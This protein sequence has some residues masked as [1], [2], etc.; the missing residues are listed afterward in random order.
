MNAVES[1]HA[2]Y[3]S[4]T[5]LAV[6][7]R[8]QERAFS[9]FLSVGYTEDDLRCVLCYLKRENKR[10]KGAAYSLRLSKLLDFEYRHF[11][12]LLSEARAKERNRVVR[13]PAQRV[14]AQ[15]RGYTETKTGP[16]V[17]TAG[18]HL[19]AMGFKV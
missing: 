16:P 2:C 17:K 9:H 10:M 1:L 5:G 19:K 13:T 3:V 6:N 18:E 11:D 12:D 7:L 8:V 15:F 4:C 14:V